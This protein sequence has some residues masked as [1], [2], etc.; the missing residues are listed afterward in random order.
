MAAASNPCAP[1]GASQGREPCIS[2][3]LGDCGVVRRPGGRDGIGLTYNRFVAVAG[4]ED[5]G[6]H[7]GDLRLDGVHQALPS[8]V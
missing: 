5:V 6:Q 8:R 2:L 1:H 3:P 4:R 7:L